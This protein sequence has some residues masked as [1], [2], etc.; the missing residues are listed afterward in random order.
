MALGH[1]ESEVVNDPMALPFIYLKTMIRRHFMESDDTSKI[2]G[3]RGAVL[4]VP[5]IFELRQSKKA[6]LPWKVLMDEG[7]TVICRVMS[8]NGSVIGINL[9]KEQADA[10]VRFATV[11]RRH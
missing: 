11:P 1:S 10:L 4:W 6:P 5:C 9:N 3:Q 2:G 7:S 8:S